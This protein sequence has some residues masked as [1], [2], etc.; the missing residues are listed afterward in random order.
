MTVQRFLGS[1]W[2][3][4]HGPRDPRQLLVW[5]LDAGFAGVLAA[6]APRPIDWSAMR[7]AAV[8]LPLELPVVR[9]GSVLAAD[10]VTAGLASS[11][12]GQQATAMAAVRR[13]VET[14]AALGCRQIVLEPG[15][16]PVMGE[17]ESDDL[18]DPSYQW[19]AERGVAMVARRSVGRN[20]ALDHACRAVH[21]LVR[22]F[23]EFRF[24][25]TAGRNIRS[26]ADHQGLLD[27][28]EDLHQLP[29]GYWHDAAVGA[30]REQI[31]GEAQ[32]ELLEDLGNRLTG[33]SL[34]DA[35]PDGMQLPPGSGG[36]D[37]A[38]LATYVPRTNSFPVAIELDPS[39]A[40]GDFAGVRSCLD[41]YGL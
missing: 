31:F 40:P 30:R 29:L 38:L 13:A 25:V 35:S 28:F 9:V 14:A 8:D 7:S 1:E 6:P 23:P 16:V 32:G 2:V 15:L 20:E 17:I 27:L 34:G 11:R 41:K 12:E 37:Y 4:V 18:G 10:S 3:S 22:G 26:I 39:V 36:V 19:S 33:M 5:V 24:S 21:Q